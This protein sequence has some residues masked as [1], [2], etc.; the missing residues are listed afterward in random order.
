MAKWRFLTNH[1]LVLIHVA[2]TPRTTLRE[3]SAAVGITERAT[4]TI[5]RALEQDG[6]ISRQKDGRRKRYWMNYK[7][8]LHHP[9]EGPYK[10]VV[11]LVKALMD[12]ARR[13]GESDDLPPDGDEPP[14]VPR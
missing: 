8:L 7:A 11:E 12:L 5:L 9:L 2:N 4:L 13:L 14:P 1:A 3:I 10:T 6:L